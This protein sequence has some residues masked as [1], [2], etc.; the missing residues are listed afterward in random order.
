MRRRWPIRNW[1]RVRN[2]AVLVRKNV[3][4]GWVCEI[5]EVDVWVDVKFGVIFG[6][7]EAVHQFKISGK[8]AKYRF[9]SKKK[10]NYSAMHK[11]Y[12]ETE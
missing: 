6:S 10:G 4:V 7:I 11:R 8:K 1:M 5:M 9:K 2:L 3:G 12:R